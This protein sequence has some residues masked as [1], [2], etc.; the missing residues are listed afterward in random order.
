MKITALALSIVLAGCTAA[1]NLYT[2]VP[3]QGQTAQQTSADAVACEAK[4]HAVKEKPTIFSG[5][6]L[7]WGIDEQAYKKEYRNCMAAKGYSLKEE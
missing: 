2:A 6:L 1:T 5:S 4:A 3:M 7:G